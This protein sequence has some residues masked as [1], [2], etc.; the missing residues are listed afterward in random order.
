MLGTIPFNILNTNMNDV[1]ENT[2]SKFE[3]N[4]KQRVRVDVPNSRASVQRDLEKFLVYAN[5]NLIKVNKVVLF[6]K[7]ASPAPVQDNLSSAG[8]DL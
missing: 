7:C 8:K 1:T 3:D 6:N 4:A 2:L 5:R